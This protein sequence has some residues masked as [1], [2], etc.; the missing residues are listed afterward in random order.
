MFIAAVSAV[1]ARAAKPFYMPIGV[2][3]F[4]MEILAPGLMFL[5]SFLNIRAAHL[6]GLLAKPTANQTFTRAK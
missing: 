2:R 4:L 6:S 1:V 5:L 3:L